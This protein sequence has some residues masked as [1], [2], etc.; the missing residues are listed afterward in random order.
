M[1]TQIKNN[2]FLQKSKDKYN[3]DVNQKECT[4]KKTRKETIFKKNT[5]VYNSITNQ[6]PENIKSSRDLELDKDSAITNISQLIAQKNNERT[7]LEE[8][9]KQ[10]NPKQKI[11]M[12]DNTTVEKPTT[13]TEMKKI[14][15]EYTTQHNKK[16]EINKSKYGNIMKNLKDLGIINN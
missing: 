14:Q 7:A 11:I 10:K 3:P 15:A 6:V 5:V 1:N 8:E 13:F 2:V 4:L 9:F 16:V 12:T